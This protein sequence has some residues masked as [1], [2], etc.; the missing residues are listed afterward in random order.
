MTEWGVVGVL[1]AIIG[2]F[3]TVGKPLLALN[4]SI[5]K[6]EEGMKSVNK[7]LDDLNGKNTQ[8]H[9]RIWNKVDKQ[10]ETLE[11]HEQR[12]PHLEFQNEADH[13]I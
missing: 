3:M 10:G 4:R 2:L 8:D 1:I 5:V 12:I 6:L 9:A 7:G 11:D 13:Q